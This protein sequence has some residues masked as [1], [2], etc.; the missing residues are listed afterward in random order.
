MIN[1][2]KSFWDHGVFVNRRLGRTLVLMIMGEKP[3]NKTRLFDHHLFRRSMSARLYRA[4]YHNCE[5]LFNLMMV[6][7][8]CNGTRLLGGWAYKTYDS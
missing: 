1:S 3:F 6:N 8:R 7:H 4:R 5:Y 2:F